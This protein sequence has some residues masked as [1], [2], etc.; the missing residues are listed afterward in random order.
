[1]SDYRFAVIIETAPLTHN[2]VLEAA[3]ALGA[4]G[5]LDGSIRGHAAGMEVLFERAADSMEAAMASA[6]ADVEQAGYR[7]GRVEVAR[8]AIPTVG[9][10]G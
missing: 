2:E 8:D 6:I 5:C 10:S 9:Q 1:M 4:A 3:D 7:I